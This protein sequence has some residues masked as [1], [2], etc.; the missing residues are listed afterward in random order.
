[1]EKGRR[2]KISKRKPLRGA[3]PN[4][5]HIRFM[6]TGIETT[7]MNL[8]IQSARKACEG[9]LRNASKVSCTLQRYKYN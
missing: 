1:M 8:M 9:M 5:M 7:V 2:F 4:E 6:V 3:G